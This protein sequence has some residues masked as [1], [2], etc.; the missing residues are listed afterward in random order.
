MKS[1]VDV[2]RMEQQTCGLQ[3]MI[4]FEILVR[5]M[6]DFITEFSGKMNC[7]IF[8]R[9]SFDCTRLKLTERE[10]LKPNS[11]GIEGNRQD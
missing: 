11:N 4:L 10:T 5:G 6:E 7:E 3:R 1:I 8:I 9:P 2:L